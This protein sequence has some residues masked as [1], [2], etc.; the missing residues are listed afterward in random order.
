MI[1]DPLVDRLGA[2]RLLR[3]A[4]VLAAVVLAAGLAGSSATGLAWPLLLALLVAGAGV[5]ADFPLMYGAGDAIATR[6]DLPAGTGTSAVGLMARLGGLFMPAVIGVVAG[7]A[8]LTVALG[9][10]AVAGLAAAALL[11]RLVRA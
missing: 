9:L 7:V 1:T 2:G 3:L 6:L 10:A 5:S 4:N 8:G 11:P